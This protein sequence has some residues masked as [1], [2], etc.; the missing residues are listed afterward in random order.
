MHVY[1]H[2]LFLH[3]SIFF[4]FFLNFYAV[5]VKFVFWWCTVWGWGFT[6]WQ[7]ERRCRYVC[8]TA[9]LLPGLIPGKSGFRSVNKNT[10]KTWQLSI[11]CIGNTDN[12]SKQGSDSLHSLLMS[13][14]PD[15][16]ELGE[17][18]IQS[19]IDCNLQPT[20]ISNEI[21]HTLPVKLYVFKK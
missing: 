6:G 19:S 5:D 4:L 18:R 17:G 10:P 1:F 15:A 12:W 11:C 7:E 21:L 13:S 20:D 2:H 14:A 8:K 3:L 16:F 9:A